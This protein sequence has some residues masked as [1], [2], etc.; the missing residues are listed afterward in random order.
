MD[1]LMQWLVRLNHDSH[2]GFALLTV[3]VMA[4][5]GL[6]VGTGIE[7]ILKALG[8]RYEKIEIKR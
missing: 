6:A 3:A 8:V 5:L 2:W 7:L 1:S 4:T